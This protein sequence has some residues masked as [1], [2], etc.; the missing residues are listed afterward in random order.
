MNAIRRSAD[1]GQVD[2]G[3]LQSRHSFSFG[4]YHDPAHMGFGALRVINE[5]VVQPGR[6]FGTHGHQDMEILSYVLEGALEHQ[7]S[8]GNGSVIRPG[9]VQRMTAGTGVQHSEFNASATDPVHF[10]QIWLLPSQPGLTP[11]YEQRRI[12]LR[13]QPGRWR[14]LASPDGRDGSVVVQQQAMLHAAQ[15]T[16]SEVLDFGVDPQGQYWLQVA[17]GS[18]VALRVP[19]SA[20]VQLEAGDGFAITTV[21]EE[22]AVLQLQL[23]GDADSAEVLLFEQPASG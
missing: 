22:G 18:V 20:S 12:D 15:L 11:G 2:L 21:G 10:L 13:E 1:R 19:G 4:S 8:L 7:D 3:W 17:R 14:L 16:P 5:D 23:A 6:G 9:D